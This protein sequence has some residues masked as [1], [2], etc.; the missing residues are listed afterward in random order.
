MADGTGRNGSAPDAR[1]EEARRVL[2]RVARE[3][4]SL[5]GSSFARTAVHTRD[6]FMG[7]DAD[8]EDRAEVW[9]RRIGRSLGA[10]AV[11][12]LGVWL[13]RRLLT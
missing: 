10:V 9:G 6:H 7:S 8:P 4:E 3:T 2:D 11:V 1:E 13:L 12:V 5:G